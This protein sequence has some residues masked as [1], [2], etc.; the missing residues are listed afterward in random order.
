MRA[1]GAGGL[2]LTGG[3]FD[4]QGL[5]EAVNGSTVGYT[6]SGVT[7][8]NSGGTLTGGQWRAAGAGSTIDIR[9]GR[10]S[11]TTPRSFWMAPG[12]SSARSAPRPPSLEA[13]RRPTSG[14]R[15][16]GGRDYTAV[17]GLINRGTWEMGGGTLSAGS[18]SNLLVGR[19][20]SAL[21]RW[22]R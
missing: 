13:A 16:L 2:V 5:I 14:T 15:M 22:R 8:N 4:N 6:T 17:N 12:R 20:S 18:F 21:A 3:Q 7:L 19:I 9:G 11:T 10:S 1:S